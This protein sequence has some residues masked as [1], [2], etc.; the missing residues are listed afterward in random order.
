MHNEDVISLGTN[1][2]GN[3][4]APPNTF[5]W[6]TIVVLAML[7]TYGVADRVLAEND[8]S[9]PTYTFNLVDK[10]WVEILKEF[11]QK[12]GYSFTGRT[13]EGNT[14]LDFGK[15]SVSLELASQRLAAVLLAN[16]YVLR[17]CNGTCYKIARVT[18]VYSNGIESVI[19]LED[20]FLNIP[21]TQFDSFAIMF[22]KVPEK[23]SMFKEFLAQTV[24]SHVTAKYFFGDD[25]SQ[26]KE[27]PNFIIFGDV[28]DV[29]HYLSLV[30]M[31]NDTDGTKNM[32][33]ITIPLRKLEPDDAIEV[34]QSRYQATE[35]YSEVELATQ[36]DSGSSED[37]SKQK[38]PAIIR[39]WPDSAYQRIVIT[40][41]EETADAVKKLISRY[42]NREDVPTGVTGPKRPTLKKTDETL[43]ST[44]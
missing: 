31:L 29:R 35:I 38:S 14:T 39:I 41:P 6:V 1:P 8:K 30:H 11:T 42:D 16:N 44:P 7:T 3:T 24:P 36:Q 13:P 5:S 19:F 4:M 20:D 23:T 2:K 18:E 17:G 28:R 15:E 37:A 40:C 43:Q 10:P 12:T 22:T 21:A 9:Y 32:I 26:K 27:D 34:I 33:A 25:P